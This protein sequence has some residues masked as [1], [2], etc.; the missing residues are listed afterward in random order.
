MATI[1]KIRKHSGWVIAAIGIAMLGFLVSD[2]VS[3]G[4]L[5]LFDNRPEG[6][7]KIYGENIDPNE[8][9][10]KYENAIANYRAQLPPDES[11]SP[12]LE[13]QISDEIW[14]QFIMERIYDKEW[15]AI[16]LNVTGEEIMDL[17]VGPNPHPIAMQYLVSD[18]E[19]GKYEKDKIYQFISRIEEAGPEQKKFWLDF[20]KYLSEERSKEKY[21]GMIKNGLYV[22]ELE[23]KDGFFAGNK[24]ASVK[25]VPLFTNTIADSTIEVADKDYR[26]YFNLHRED[27]KRDESRTIEYVSFDVTSRKEDT[28]TAEKWINQ[29]IDAFKTAKNDSSFVARVGRTSFKN[30]FQRRGEFPADIEERIF[31]ADSGQVIGPFFDNGTYKLAKIVDTKTDSV[32]FYKASHI[33]I[34]P[35]G[36][37]EADSVAAMNKAKEIMNKIKAGSDFAQMAMENSQDQSNAAKGG[38]L[39]WFQA[40]TMVKRFGDAVARANSGDLFVVRTEFGAHVVKITAPR[41]NKLVKAAILERKVMPSGKTEEIAYTGAQR[42]RG[43]LARGEDFQ[44]VVVKKGFNK[45][46]AENIKPNDKMIPGMESPRELIRWVYG[47]DTKVGDVSDPIRVGNKYVVAYVTK[48]Q[49]EGYANLDEVKEQIKPMVI[50]EKKKDILSKKMNDAYGSGKSLEEIAK[51]V[52]TSVNNAEGVLFQNPFVPNLGQEPYFVGYVFG[53]KPNT[54]SKPFKGENGVFVVSVDKFGDIK[55]PENFTQEQKQMLQNE[56]GRSQNAAMNA[57]RQGAD[58]KDMRYIYY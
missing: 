33:L 20:E 22:T 44:D 30:T 17:T 45:R 27:Y 13:G 43:M 41:S 25:F 54:V 39:G 36:A 28:T 57:L 9:R 53:L 37:A 14:N 48:M 21:Y 40:S 47:S 24:T 26:D 34:K 11:I 3:S 19:T 7:G 55:V 18:R 38:D 52:G 49:E 23:A 50:N 1:S 56:Q 46:V 8:F 32:Y 51:A 4:N 35:E 42:F 29:Q 16:G 5:N 15:A 6:I 58:V 2:V 10:V 12:A 31:A